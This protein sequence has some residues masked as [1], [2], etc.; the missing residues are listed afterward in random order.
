MNRFKKWQT[1]V[2]IFA[3]LAAAAAG[4]YFLLRP[5]GSGTY[6]NLIRNGEFENRRNG[7]PADWETESYFSQRGY[8]EYGMD[9]GETGQAA[10]IRND[11]LND[12]RFF[13]TVSVSP[14]TLYCLRGRI[15]AKAQEGRGA[16]LSISDVYVFSDSVYD[17]GGEWEEVALYGRTGKDQRSV[18]VFVRLGGYGGEATGEA[19]F[20]HVTL[21]RVDSV[22]AGY[23][24]YSWYKEAS[25]ASESSG[26]SAVTGTGWLI[27]IALAYCGLFFL[28]MTRQIGEDTAFSSIP[29][30]IVITLLGFAARCLIA[31]K[32][33][34]Y[35]VDIA[36]FRSWA[37]I[38]SQVGPMRFYSEVGFCDYPPGYLLALWPLGVI[39]KALG[40]GTTEFMVKLPPILADAALTVLIFR[41]VK[42]HFSGHAA[43]TCAV[44]FAFNP[45]TILTGAAWGQ[46]DSV[47]LLLLFLT[48]LFAMRKRWIAA[49]P[50]YIAAVLVKPQALMF[51]PLGLAA[52]ILHIVRSVRQKDRLKDMLLDVGL[53]LAAMLFTALSMLLPFLSQQPQPLTW[54]INLYSGTMSQYHYVT[55]NACNLY[56]LLNENWVSAAGSIQSAG[57]ALTAIAVYFAAVLPLGLAM[58][59]KCGAWSVTRQGRI[60]LYVCLALIA[61]LGFSL[62]VLFLLGGMTYATL[63]TVMIVFSVALYAALLITGGRMDNLPLLGAALLLS[64]FNGG[65]MMHERYL[66]PAVGLLLLAYAHKRDR[67]ILLLALGVSIFG[68]LN[69]GCA[70]DRNIRIGGAAGHLNAP[71]VG[72]DSDMKALEWISAVGNTLCGMAGMYLSAV[73]L[74]GK[75]AVK[76]GN[77]LSRET[78]AA[79][80][81]P[82]QKPLRPQPLPAPCALARMGAR[83]WLIML[84]I[85]VLY[86]ALA[87]NNLGSAVSPQNAWVSRQEDECV[88]FDLGEERTFKML[89]FNG[90]HWL[91]DD[92]SKEFTVQTS[93]DAIQWGRDYEGSVKNGSD[94]NYTFDCFSWKYIDLPGVNGGTGA[95]MTGR[96]VRLISQFPD[97][98]IYEV[99]FRDAET[100]ETLPVAA[101]VDLVLLRDAESGEL[102]SDQSAAEPMRNETLPCLT[103]EQDTLQGEPSWYNSTYF[104]EI[105]HARTAY[106]HLHGLRV[107]E[108]THPP[109]GKVLMSFAIA[110]FGMTPFGWRFA[111]ALAGVLMLPGMYLL[112]KTLIRRRWGGP[113]AAL[114][115][116][117]D[118]MHFTQTRI[119]TIDSFVVL[120][121]IWAVYFML[122]WFMMEDPKIPLIRTLI[123]LG[124]SGACM[125]LAVASKWT[126]CYA[127]VGLALMFC[128]GLYRRFRLYAALRRQDAEQFILDAEARSKDALRAENGKKAAKGQRFSVQQNLTKAYAEA[129]A[130]RSPWKDRRVINLLITVGSCLIFFVAVPLIIYFCAYIPYFAPEGGVTVNKIMRAAEHMLWYH[131]QPGL[132]MSHWFYSPWYEWPV[133]AK[134]MWYY[135]GGSEVPEGFGSSIMAMGNPAVWWAGLLGIVAL[136][137]CMALVYRRRSA[138]WNDRDQAL[139]RRYD[140]PRWL[141]VL[142]CFAAQ[143]LPW[144]LVPRGTYI[145]HYFPSVPFII[146]ATLLCLD[147]LSDRFRRTALIVVLALIAVAATLF[148]EFFPYASGIIV[149]T[150]WLEAMRWFPSWLWY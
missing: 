18:T 15:K 52:L 105:Y 93:T 72:I 113:A 91:G 75:A 12:A 19:W 136:I 11:R 50:L 8:T 37:D 61:A 26:A 128:F 118:L 69:V 42:K 76:E 29:A 134:P 46:A 111:G 79:A 24:E 44:F 70:L 97:L 32:V 33:P 95:V 107:Y 27:L 80:A 59:K 99:L 66:F 142:I 98:T 121:I 7:L 132:G 65:T 35:D 92:D 139:F 4:L 62:M 63:G 73:L 129:D 25:A 122:R 102:L 3:V 78:K 117:L 2:I 148:I 40:T 114:L 101:V 123:P 16:N 127:G 141:L 56:F 147:F 146:L 86:A 133:I 31:L 120:F 125:G 49:L 81:A 5:T 149:S 20:D 87:F 43:L 9:A 89:F 137:P 119:A 14:N 77:A 71:A 109:L 110:I 90:I 10:Y 21:N 130:L 104:D 83:D 13:Q 60:T 48:V 68:A 1:W 144:V 41:E 116:A 6:D 108:N 126:G 84:L 112:G 57:G 115:M 55:V 88:V 150:E 36:C 135:S 74:D 106:E 103:D 82:V 22:P 94:T 45:L 47:M 30:L 143:Y 23:R 140:D 38:L 53:G 100:G 34:G 64:L 131:S 124:L 67:R 85:T 58:L 145:Y 17:T 138:A 28:L 51:G 39:G 96:Y 54:L